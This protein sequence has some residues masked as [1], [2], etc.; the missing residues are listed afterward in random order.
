MYFEE[1]SL[2]RTFVY[3]FGE[4]GRK[5]GL[6]PPGTSETVP[7]L[8]TIQTD[9]GSY[10]RRVGSLS[11]G[12]FAAGEFRQ[13]QLTVTTEHN[14]NARTGQNTQETIL[15]TANVNSAN[16][17]K[18]FSVTVDGYVYAQ[19]LYLSNVT[20]KGATHNVVYVATEADDVYAIDADNGAV[21]W[22]VTFINLSKGI[23]T[24]DSVA[25]LN[26]TDLT[27]QVG[28]TS[29]PVIDT[30]NG[31][32]F[33]VAKTKENG[34]LRAAIARTGC[35][36]RRGKVQ[37][38]GRDSGVGLGDGRRQQSRRHQFRSAE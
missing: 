3:V 28:I 14:D 29:T 25:D 21:L 5:L 1:I 4:S 35:D 31:T 38:S 10:R 22:Y 12:S 2:L 15:T 6:A 24:V 32:I 16:F 19:P 7:F 27:P 34:A 20:I 8:R 9:S 26:C 11:R 18:L 36:N 37:R 13:T 30:V 17:G 33:V 23:T